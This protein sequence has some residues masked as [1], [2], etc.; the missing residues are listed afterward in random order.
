MSG[1]SGMRRMGDKYSHISRFSHTSHI[2]HIAH[3][4]GD[5]AIGYNTEAERR[6]IN[7]PADRERT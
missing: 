3:L 2:S 7:K 5:R 6:K 1:M 4:I